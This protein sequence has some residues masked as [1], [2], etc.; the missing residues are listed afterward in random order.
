MPCLMILWWQ[1]LGKN[2]VRHLSVRPWRLLLF[3]WFWLQYIIAYPI[4]RGTMV[5]FVA[6]KSRHDLENSKYSGAWVCSSEKSELISIFRGWEPEVQAL[7]DVC[8]KSNWRWK[9]IRHA[10]HAN[11]VCRQTSAVGDPYSEASGLFREW[12]CR[13]SWWRCKNYYSDERQKLINNVGT[14]NYS[15]SRNRS[16]SSNWGEPFSLPPRRWLWTKILFVRMPTFFLL[17]WDTDLPPAKRYHASYAFTTTLEDPFP[18]K[19]R[20]EHG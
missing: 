10:H 14:R 5:N 9:E 11:L 17:Y 19:P 20:S 12:E 18:R 7:L 13:S 8:Q 15:S 16:R 4:S 2:A 3:I 1:Y 6:F